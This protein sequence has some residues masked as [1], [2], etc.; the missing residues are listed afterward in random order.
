MKTPRSLPCTIVWTGRS[1]GKHRRQRPQGA[2]WTNTGRRIVVPALV[3]A[4]LGAVGASAAHSAGDHA[5]ASAHPSAERLA[6][7]SAD[8]WI[9]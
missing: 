8:P 1:P 4:S 9:W 6:A 2:A 5:H 3:L 7:E